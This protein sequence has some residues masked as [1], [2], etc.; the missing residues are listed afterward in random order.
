MGDVDS[1][2]AARIPTPDRSRL[3]W[4]ALAAV[5]AAALL[6]VVVRYLGI[7]A[8]GAFLYYVGRPVARRLEPIVGTAGRAAAAT[9]VAIV[10]PLLVVLWIVAAV[11]VGQLL[12]L[13]DVDVDRLVAAVEPTL[14]VEALPQTPSE[15]FDVVREDVRLQDATALVDLGVGVLARVGGLV[16]ATTLLFAFV[17]LLL[18][19]DRDVSR[20]VRET[21]LGPESPGATYLR[22]VD[23]ELGR[24]YG[25][26]MLTILVVVVLAWALYTALNLIAPPGLSIPF[27]ALLALVTGAATFV[28]LI[29]RSLV[30][31]PIVVYLAAVALATD[32]RLLWFPAVT[33]LAGVFGLDS[34]VRYGVRPYLSSH[35]TPSVVMLV[36]YVLGSAVFGWYGVFLAPIVVVAIRQ[37]LD[38]VFPALVRG[39]PIPV[40]ARPGDGDSTDE[41]DESADDV[42]DASTADHH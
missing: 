38:S 10:L 31:A 30:Y 18:C 37:F 5:V 19:Y 14:G 11:A 2:V 35:G 9:M 12:A 22:A 3:G 7:V 40:P 17:Y 16:F 41:G 13:T 25:G 21:V 36:G 6:A 15:L 33:G 42:D 39:D 32:P 8:F 23:R 24:V 4:W 26:Q 34:I 29:G 20:W 1:S 28:P 27:P